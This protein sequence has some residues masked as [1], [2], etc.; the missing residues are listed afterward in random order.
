MCLRFGL[1]EE[2]ENQLFRFGSL[3]EGRAVVALA[4]ADLM[5]PLWR[6]ADRS[7]TSGRC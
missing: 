6:L 2:E 5:C 3:L 4:C 7:K 1:S